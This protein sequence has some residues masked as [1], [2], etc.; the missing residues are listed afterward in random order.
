MTISNH[1]LKVG[2][3]KRI[4]ILILNATITKSILP[5][6]I[7]TIKRNEQHVAMANSEID[8]TFIFNGIPFPSKKFLM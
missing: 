8:K 7:G 5:I 6:K 3:K 1:S 4:Y 2:T